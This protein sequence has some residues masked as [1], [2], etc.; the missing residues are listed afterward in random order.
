MLSADEP[1]LNDLEL[2]D[3]AVARLDKASAIEL[4]FPMDFILDT[5][6]DFVY[7]PSGQRTDGRHGQY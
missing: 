7:G 1:P 5:T 3:D 6:S 4:G 2:P